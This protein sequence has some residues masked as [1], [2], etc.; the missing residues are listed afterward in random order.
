MEDLVK[1]RRETVARQLVEV[2][3]LKARVEELQKGEVPAVPVVV[4]EG[5]VEGEVFQ[6]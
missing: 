6:G 5:V 4:A 3:L 1:Q 2:E